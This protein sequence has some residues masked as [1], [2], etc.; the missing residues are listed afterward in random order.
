[1]QNPIALP[2]RNNGHIKTIYV[3]FILRF[4]RQIGS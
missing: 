1:M 4:T 2:E 3:G